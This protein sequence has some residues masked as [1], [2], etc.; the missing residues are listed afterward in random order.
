[1]YSIILNPPN[2][3]LLFACLSDKKKTK[4]A[5]T[6]TIPMPVPEPHRD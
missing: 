4:Q 1:M 6:A 2:I 3:F 5:T